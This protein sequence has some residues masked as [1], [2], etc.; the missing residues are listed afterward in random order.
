MVEAQYRLSDSWHVLP[1]RLHTGGR[2]GAEQ[3]R[4]G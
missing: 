2:A 1:G 4:L 3:H